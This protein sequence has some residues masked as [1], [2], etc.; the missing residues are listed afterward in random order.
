MTSANV[1]AMVAKMLTVG[2]LA[3]A[4]AVAAP[5]KAQAQWSFGVRIGG[6]PGYGPGYPVVV[7]PGPMY[8]Y[9]GHVDDDDQNYYQQS[10]NYYGQGNYYNPGYYG[11][12]YDE[13]RRGGYYGQYREDHFDR[14]RFYGDDRHDFRRGER[15]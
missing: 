6:D 2:F 7:A 14:N 5:T 3:V 12:G 10:P 8:G 1:K 15:H 13:D 9:G 11:R 4:V